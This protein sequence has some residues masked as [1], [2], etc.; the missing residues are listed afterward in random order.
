MTYYEIKDTREKGI[1]YKEISFKGFK[2]QWLP[3][4][5]EAEARA[6]RSADRWVIQN[7]LKYKTR[8]LKL[9]Q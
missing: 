7:K 9:K 2:T 1:A 5:K 3:S 6:I 4:D 8:K